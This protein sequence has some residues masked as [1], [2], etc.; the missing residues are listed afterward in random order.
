[1]CC[2][3]AGSLILGTVP[4][5][6]PAPSDLHLSMYDLSCLDD[7]SVLMLHVQGP[8]SKRPA[9][10]VSDV[11][12]SR[13][14]ERERESCVFAL[15]VMLTA[16]TDQGQNPALPPWEDEMP[17]LDPPCKDAS[18]QQSSRGQIHPC[19]PLDTSR[20]AT[21]DGAQPVNMLTSAFGGPA[22]KVRHE[23]LG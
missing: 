17:F 9:Y 8:S 18:C 22:V 16:S 20:P 14:R 5:R 23:L 10:N 2:I 21:G 7:N 19:S 13:E 15:F 12:H 1:M 6:L 11:P 4:M 3:A